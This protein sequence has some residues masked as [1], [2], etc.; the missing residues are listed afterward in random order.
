MKI[1]VVMGGVSSERAIS[2]KSGEQVYDKAI[3]L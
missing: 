3:S 2:L 1:G